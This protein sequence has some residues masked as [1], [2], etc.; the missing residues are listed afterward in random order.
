MW[1]ALALAGLKSIADNRAN[2]QNIQANIIKE[3]YSPWTGRGGD[4]SQQ[5][6]NSTVSNMIAGYGSGL[7]Q[8]KLDAEA[9]ASKVKPALQDAEPGSSDSLMQ[10]MGQAPSRASAFAPLA[11]AGIS[12]APAVMPG[13]NMESQSFESMFMPQDQVQIPFMPQTQQQNPWL[14]MARGGR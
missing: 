5:G 4:F 10:A 3:K 13:G 9:I 8:D 1:Q 6:K 7:L 11:K 14:M 12:R 2:Q